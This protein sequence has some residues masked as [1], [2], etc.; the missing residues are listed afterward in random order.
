MKNNT[1][2]AIDA[3]LAAE[4]SIE[5]INSAFKGFAQSIIKHQESVEKKREQIEK[6]MENG[7]RVT[8]NRFRL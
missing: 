3:I 7:A 5:R 4:P 6:E 8:R 1:E 2:T